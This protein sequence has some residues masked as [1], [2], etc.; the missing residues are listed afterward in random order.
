[1]TIVVDVQ[2]D[3]PVPADNPSIPL[4]DRIAAAAETTKCL[5]SM[6]CS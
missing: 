1:M 6:A 5:P 3:V 2:A 4:A